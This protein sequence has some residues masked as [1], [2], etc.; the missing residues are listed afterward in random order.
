MSSFQSIAQ[1]KLNDSTLSI[2]STVKQTM[3]VNDITLRW[4]TTLLRA[5]K[6]DVSDD[7]NR[8]QTD[9]QQIE[10]NKLL[11]RA[12][13]RFCLTAN[14]SCRRG[15]WANVRRASGAG[16]WAWR[17]RRRQTPLSP[18]A[19]PIS[20]R[21]APRRVPVPLGSLLKKQNKQHLETM[22]ALLK[23]NLI[24]LFLIPYSLSIRRTCKFDFCP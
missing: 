13:L 5:A 9:R 16:S 6:S 19:P 4:W 11:K 15:T 2:G 22:S 1:L 24:Y 7:G 8:R 3:N 17:R 12:P 20:R 10:T 18:P 14:L 23:F 21:K